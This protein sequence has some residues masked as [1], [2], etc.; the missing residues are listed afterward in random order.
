MAGS[1]GFSLEL[2]GEDGPEQPALHMVIDAARIL[3]RKQRAA[4][5]ASAGFHAPAA[6]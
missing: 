4:D 1:I 6:R 2:A 5:S 3:G